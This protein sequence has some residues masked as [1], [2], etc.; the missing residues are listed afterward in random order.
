MISVRKIPD[1]LSD[2]PILIEI[3]SNENEYKVDSG[4]FPKRNFKRDPS[5]RSPA[6]A[7][8]VLN[9]AEYFQIPNEF[10]VYSDNNLS[11]T[12]KIIIKEIYKHHIYDV[13]KD[14]ISTEV[15]HS[16]DFKIKYDVFLTISA[17][18]K[19]LKIPDN[20]FYYIEDNYDI[21]RDYIDSGDMENHTFTVTKY[22]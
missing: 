17:D 9:T 3:D 8:L 19:K 12:L 18:Y 7:L 2:S 21:Y 5:V 11:K 4:M 20:L 13:I 6:D 14:L 1:W 22:I 10:W 15:K 16:N